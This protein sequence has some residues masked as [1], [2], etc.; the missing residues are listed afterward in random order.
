ME[1]IDREKYMIKEKVRCGN[2]NFNTVVFIETLP[3]GVKYLAAYNK[4]GTFKIQKNILYPKT[5]IF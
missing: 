3:N 4:E 5:I 1:K 2:Y